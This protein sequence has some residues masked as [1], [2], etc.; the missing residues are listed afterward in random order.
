MDAT[1][2]SFKKLVL[3]LLFA[4]LCLGPWSSA[5]HAQTLTANPSTVSW[6][7]TTGG[8]EPPNQTINLTDSQAASWSATAASQAGDSPWLRLY[9]GSNLSTSIGPISFSNGTS[10]FTIVPL[11]SNVAALSNGLHSTTITISDSV[12][13]QAIVTVT[14]SVNG[15]STNNGLTVAPSTI[16]LPQVAAGSTTSVSSAASITSLS[17]G[18]LQSSTSGTCLG[19]SQN[20]NAS[21]ITANGAAVTLTVIGNPSGVPQATYNNCSVTVNLLNGASTVIATVNVPITWVVGTGSGSS[22]SLVLP[23]TLN[24]VEQGTNTTS[25]VP[26]TISIAGSGSWTAAISIPTGPG[27]WI[28]LGTGVLGGVGPGI[29]TITVDPTTAG[30]TAGSY[31]GTVTFT[32][33]GGGSQAVTVNLLISAS[34]VIFA[35]LASQTA[36]GPGSQTF[37]VVASDGSSIAYTA[38]TSTPWLSILSPASDSTPSFVTYN[39]N[40]AALPN[41]VYQGAITLTNTAAANTTLSVPV[42]LTVTGSTVTGGSLTFNTSALT[43]NAQANGS[44]PGAQTLTV[45]APAGTS[46]SVSTSTSSGGNWLAVSPSGLISISPMNFTVTATQGTLG[47]GTY[48]GTISFLLGSGTT[49]T[50][51]VTMNV[52]ATAT[53]LSFSPTSLTFNDT[54]GGATPATQTFTVSSASGSASTTFTLTSDSTWLSATASGTTTPATITVTAN[55][56]G[57]AAQTYSGNLVLTPAG[58]TSQKFPVTF[59]ITS[60]TVTAS[61]TTLNLAYAVG[62]TPPTATINVGGTGA[63]GAALNYTATLTSACNCLAISP[64]SGT[65]TANPTITVSLLNPTSLTAGTFTGTVAVGG[66]NG[67]TGNT[68]VNITLTVTAPL[69]TL[70][71]IANAASGA[72]GMIAPGE[73]VSLFGTAANPI[74]PAT[75]VQLSASLLTSSG[76]V[77]TTMGGVTVTFNGRPAPLLYVSATQVNAVVPYGVAGF[78]NFPV[79]VNYLG[80]TSN[81][82]TVQTTTT[83]PG[84]FTLNGGG[85]GP[86]AILNSDGKTANGPNTPAAKGSTVAVF[87]TG[88]GMTTPPG[89]DGKVTCAAGCTSLS[90]IPIPLLPV[91]VLVDGQPAAVVF[92]GEAPSLVSG[93]MQV[94]FTIPTTVRSG[95]VPLT[96]AVGGNQ[97]QA[98]VTVSV[99]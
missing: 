20:L 59:V 37:Q 67:A 36:S 22:G 70:A 64:T 39:V 56:T 4:L 48:N 49:Q 18:T 53:T 78:N 68:L 15:T 92:Y 17:S 80:Q 21:F 25:L 31:T 41:G 85:S 76:N 14:V 13:N 7:F 66:T 30:L 84:I 43:F 57:L 88:E 55:P 35:N 94:N 38:S 42:V 12:G 60:P 90:Q 73:I 45:T 93:V 89:V 28:K 97:S 74:G 11:P 47:I 91:S 2:T 81:G 6:S 3:F 10:S 79:I 99:Q 23:A 63:G 26:Q 61:P 8:A 71:S 65:T 19:I 46:Y 82:F 24:F 83:V 69:P 62:G 5:A 98:N 29:T 40:T 50:V 95:N 72:T 44:A 54:V 52:T 77:P 87:L 51:G 33:A 27:G 1:Y 16:A 34:P 75:P 58:G 9:D 96:I 32:F 86:A